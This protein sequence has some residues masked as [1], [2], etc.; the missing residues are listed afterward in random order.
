MSTEKQQAVLEPKTDALF[1]KHQEVINKAVKAIHD[2]TF[3]AA[4]PEHPKAYAPEAAANAEK[5]FNQ[6]C[7]KA[8]EELLQTGKPTW[9]GEENSPYWNKPLGITYPK[10]T[11]DTLVSGAQ[12]AFKSWRKV[13]A[14]ERAGILVESLDRIKNRFFEIAYATQHTTGQSF[15]MSFQA[16]GPHAADRA[17]EAIALGY[18]ELKRFP[19]STHWEKPMGKISLHLDKTFK[20]IPKGVGLIIGCS[21]FPTWNT[22]P[23]LYA[24]L[25]TGNSAIVKPHPRAVLPIAIVVA[26]IQKVLK[27]K[28]LDP[29]TVQ[30]GMDTSTEL[31]AK[32]LAENPAITS[33]DYTGGSTFGTYIESLGTKK[34]V[35]TEKAGVNPV[36]IDSAQD[37]REVMRNLAFSVSLYSGQMCTAPQNLFIPATGIPVADGGKV[38]YKEAVEL[39]KNEVAAL[40]LHPKK[41]AGTLGAIQSPA[42]LA[43]AEGAKY[44]GGKVILE[45]PEVKNPQFEQARICAPSILEVDAADKHIYEKELFGPVSLVIKTKDTAHSVQLAKSIVQKH[46]AITCALYCT[47]EAK[48]ASITEEMNDVFAPVSLNLTGYTFINQHA[49]F[50]DFHVTGGNPSG[51]ASFT[52]PSYINKR[53]VWVGNRVANN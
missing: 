22:V 44:L 21:T 26:E 1:T 30:L 32:D 15:G 52:D 11:V 28:G 29:N 7:G 33:I 37:L 17:M 25:I 51:N 9:V 43:R 8:F 19:K 34:A 36:I 41:G 38:S 31:I 20:A 39:F 13:S 48:A 50:S 14:D 10:Y 49:A 6:Q 2:R 3:Y 23:G 46:G 47:N 4:Y 12:K 35:F 40:A 24:T 18:H 53:F 27:E 45:A 5:A 16:S 42:T